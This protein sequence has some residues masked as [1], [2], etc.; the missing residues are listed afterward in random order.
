MGDLY[1]NEPK[2]R[3]THNDKTLASMKENGFINSAQT[4]ISENYISP[5]KEYLGG[6]VNE[7]KQH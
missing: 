4:A 6:K 3:G 7:K 2:V 1:D 5:W